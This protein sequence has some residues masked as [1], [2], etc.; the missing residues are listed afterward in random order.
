M[1]TKVS[2]ILEN[3]LSLLA[4]EGSFEVE[5]KDE[6]FYVKIDTED[7][8][9]LIGRQGE[10]LEAL[11]MMVNLIVY[12]QLGT[13]K[14]VYIDVSEWKA[15]KESDLAE[16]TK[17]WLE[18]VKSEGKEMQLDFMPAWQRRIV[19]MVVSEDPEVESESVGEGEERR[20]VIRPKAKA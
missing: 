3:I 18:Q 2:E 19:H 8:G 11:Q 13:E 17:L 9:K 1:E 15:G 14:R 4:L 20:L 5:E 7:A 16:K 6:A 12:K 10:T